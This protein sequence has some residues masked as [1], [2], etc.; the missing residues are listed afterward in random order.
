MK[1]ERIV[2]VDLMP[3][4]M[5]PGNR[6]RFARAVGQ[7]VLKAFDNDRDLEGVLLAL[8]GPSKA[9]I[10]CRDIDHSW[11]CIHCPTRLILRRPRGDSWWKPRDY[12]EREADL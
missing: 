3:D 1:T 9:G 7:A 8:P 12:Y 5:E 11:S 2:A 4:F 6:G 10:R